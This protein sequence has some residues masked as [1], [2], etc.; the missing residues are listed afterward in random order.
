MEG[1]YK[2]ERFTITS[3]I[4]SRYLSKKLQNG[5]DT[6]AMYWKWDENSS[7]LWRKSKE[8]CIKM[9]DHQNVKNGFHRF[10]KLRILRAKSCAVGRKRKKIMKNFKKILRFFLSKSLWKIEFFH[11]FFLKITWISNSAPKVYTSRR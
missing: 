7:K 1:P 2:P 9:E 8:I 3:I 11:I 4:K 5:L 10:G 6:E